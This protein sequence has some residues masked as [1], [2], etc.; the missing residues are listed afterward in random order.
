[1]DIASWV[2]IIVTGLVLLSDLWLYLTDRR[3]YSQ[4]MIKWSKQVLIVS[5]AW[6]FLM[7]HWFG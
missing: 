4:V 3:T 5:F 6:G 2:I 7:G 1:M